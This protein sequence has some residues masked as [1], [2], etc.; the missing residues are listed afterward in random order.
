M[1][2]QYNFW[3]IFFLFV[4]ICCNRGAQ[5]QNKAL[6][7]SAP[8]PMSNAFFVLDT[9]EPSVFDE[10]FLNVH[11]DKDLID[12]LD[13]VATQC[14]IQLVGA[15]INC[16]L[17]IRGLLEDVLNASGK[18]GQHFDT[19]SWYLRYAN[20]EKKQA[21]AAY[22]LR[23]QV[24]NIQTNEAA[25][26]LQHVQW[27]RFQTAFSY[28][29]N[30]R[31]ALV[32]DGTLAAVAAMAGANAE[33][34]TLLQ[35]HFVLRARVLPHWMRF[36][37]MQAFSYID[38]WA[39]RAAASGEVGLLRACLESPA[40]MMA[41]THEE[42]VVLC[43]W[44]REMLKIGRIHVWPLIARLYR[45]CPQKPYV[46]ELAEL[47][48]SFSFSEVQGRD[49]ADLGDLWREQ[50]SSHAPISSVCVKL[51][52]ILKRISMVPGLAPEIQRAVQSVLRSDAH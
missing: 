9:E 27:E 29:A 3:F 43:E 10:V 48:L 36:A 37:R 47:L 52:E 46:E 50:C 18:F 1:K 41:W 33:L 15:Q 26:T 7:S 25:R 32:L 21:V 17:P 8:S 12:R 4:I 42:A 34:D 20:D 35:R 30:A 40:R 38:A 31:L 24:S 44:S 22:V 16:P 39:R 45:N 28:I 14:E 5:T 6:A 19:F 51:Q 2:I 49:I 13:A 23:W 11:P